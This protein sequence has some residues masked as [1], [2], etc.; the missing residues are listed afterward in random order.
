MDSHHI[1]RRRGGDVVKVLQA[2]TQPTLIIGITSDLLC[3]LEEQQRMAASIP[4][5][6]FI[7]ID[8]MYGHDGFLVEWKQVSQHLAEWMVRS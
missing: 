3:P 7:G 4:G 1:A 5:A 2:I 6:T 8:S